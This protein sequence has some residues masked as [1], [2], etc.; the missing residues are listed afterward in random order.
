MLS[1]S[2][3]KRMKNFMKA[4]TFLDNLEDIWFTIRKAFA[5]KYWYWLKC[6]LLPSW[7]FHILDLRKSG[8]DYTYGWRDTDSRML[9]ACFLLLVEYVEKEKPFEVIDWSWDDKTKQVGLE[10]KDLY[11][12]WT[13]RRP[14]AKKQLAADWENEPERTQF[15][16]REDGGIQIKSPASHKSLLQREQD[17]DADDQTNLER[18][19]KIRG[20]LWT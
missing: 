8:N 9:H 4:E 5:N 11:E 7:R 6:H 16:P 1:T 18:L 10:I 3:Y 17:L 19:I 15:I 2:T 14:S 20:F 13:I 12:W